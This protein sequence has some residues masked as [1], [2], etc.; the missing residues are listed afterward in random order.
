MSTDTEKTRATLL[1]FVIC[2]TKGIKSKIS[3]KDQKSVKNVNYKNIE[4]KGLDAEQY[5]FLILHATKL[6]INVRRG[7]VENIEAFLSAFIALSCVVIK[8]EEDSIRQ[9]KR[10]F[11]Y[12][13]TL[14][15]RFT[16]G[17]V[18]LE[19]NQCRRRPETRSFSDKRVS[20]TGVKCP[21]ND[22]VVQRRRV[23]GS[24]DSPSSVPSTGSSRL[25]TR[26]STS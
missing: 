23:V 6:E 22:N 13:N 4:R 24:N 21:E 19:G 9:R 2:N 15:L 5:V 10:I 26:H 12:A 3:L 1:F 25:L 16:F 17:S 18:G 11:V 8:K 7:R 14:P 20:L